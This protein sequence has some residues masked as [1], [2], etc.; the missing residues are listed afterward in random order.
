VS[1]RFFYRFI[2]ARENEGKRWA[3]G[4]TINLFAVDWQNKK[5]TDNPNFI[6][7]NA[8]LTTVISSSLILTSTILM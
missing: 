4:D 5:F 3:V 7:Q 8:I 2:G 6:L 1:K